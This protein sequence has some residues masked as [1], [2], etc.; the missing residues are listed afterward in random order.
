MRTLKTIEKQTDNKYL[1]MYKAT[2]ESK[3]QTYDYFFASRKDKDNLLAVTQQVSAD[4]V[5]ILP[6]L[7]KDGKTFVVLIKEFRHPLNRVIYS[8]PA[9]LVD[10]GESY[11]QAVARELKEETGYIVKS[12]SLVQ[13]PAFTTAGMSDEV[14]VS[15]AAKVEENEGMSLEATEDIEVELVDLDD[16]LTVLSKQEFGSQSALQLRAF[17]YEKKLEEALNNNFMCIV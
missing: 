13:G 3:S 2:Y 10:K 14:V 15:Y 16:V 12:V 17:Y 7:E 6:Y 5:R 11:E 1:N 4:D 8:L 9:G